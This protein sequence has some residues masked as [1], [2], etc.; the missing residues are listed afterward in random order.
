NSAFQAGE[1]VF[2][3]VL[4]LQSTRNA[5]Y[6]TFYCICDDAFL[7]VPG[8]LGQFCKATQARVMAA[9]LPSRNVFHIMK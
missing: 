9:Y 3:R 4:L 2:S 5:V 8:C 1:P 7:C 6:L